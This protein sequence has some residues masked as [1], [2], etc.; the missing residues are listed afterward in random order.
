[1]KRHDTSFHLM[2]NSNYSLHTI[3]EAQDLACFLANCFPNPETTLFGLA[4]LLVNAV[5]HGN[6][7][8]SYDEKTKLLAKGKL[9]DEIITRQESEK[10]KNRKVDVLFKRTK[11]SYIIKIIDEGKGFEWKEFMT[12][13]PS[14]AS[15]NHGRG[16]AQANV[17]SFNKI[18]YNASSNEVIATVDTR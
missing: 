7:E 9:H 2:N 5:E 12:V 4:E 18:K 14:R 10:Y 3:E 6:L 8:I 11:E 13:A 15:D 17:I 16:I 1:M